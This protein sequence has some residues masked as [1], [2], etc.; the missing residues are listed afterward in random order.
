MTVVRRFLSEPLV[1]FLL[2]G[3]V[4]F[5]AW[6]ARRPLAAEADR[7]V[8]EVGPGRIAQLVETFSRTW[9]RPPTPREL[10]GLIEAFVKEEIFY[11]EGRE[12]G[13]DQNDTVFRRR[14]QQKME[15]LIEPREEELNPT[16]G[17]LQTYL[18]E[19]AGSIPR[20]CP[21]RLP[22]GIFR[23]RQARRRDR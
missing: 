12:I 7:Q 17:E 1:Q 9:Q 6:S 11:R 14:L 22:A 3:V 4:V 21:R 19:N 10:N 5:A 8:I 15:F 16:D 2:I 23:S 13:L 18:G 20:S